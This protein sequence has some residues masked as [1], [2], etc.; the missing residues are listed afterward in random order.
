MSDPVLAL[1][2]VSKRFSAAATDRRAWTR[3][4]RHALFG[5]DPVT[6]LTGQGAVAALT[7]V[8]LIV[9]RGEAVG[10][11]GL[12]GAGKTTL[13]RL[14]AG[15]LAADAGTVRRAGR[16]GTLMDLTAGF[17]PDL[18][19]REAIPLACAVM[20][21][22]P[23][24]AAAATPHIVAFCGLGTALDRPVGGYSS[25]M[26]LRLGFAVAAH[27]DPDLLLIDEVLSVGDFPFRQKCLARMMALKERAGVVLVSHNL[28]EVAR[29]CDRVM[30][31]DGGRVMFDGL[32]ED[33]LAAYRRIA[34]G[35][36]AS[37][38]ADPQPDGT[39]AFLTPLFRDADRV[40]PLDLAWLDADGHPMTAVPFGAPLTLRLS[41]TLAAPARALSVGVPLYAPDG[42]RVTGLAS[43]LAQP[44]L[45]AGTGETVT[46]LLRLEAPRLNPGPW[47]GVAALHDGPGTLAR[48]PLPPLTVTGGP[49]RHWGHWTPDSRW[50]LR[51]AP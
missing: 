9:R 35:A 8:S 46:V 49:S 19:G 18:T 45:S 25:G 47:H 28:A 30:V 16:V 21:L 4:V 6:P 23:A 43:D 3:Q 17:S 20:G 32:A 2:D 33:G 1:V 48:Q 13:L 11:V 5:R 38:P 37:R 36:E 7:D 51:V 12:N 24:E 27:T 34:E 22:S 15:H 41:A 50:T 14:A 42:T 10:V 31:L 39:P 29:F 44:P 26:A 40:G